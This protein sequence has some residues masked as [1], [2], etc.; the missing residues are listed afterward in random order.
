[1]LFLHAMLQNGK[2]CFCGN[3]NYAKYGPATCSV[4]CS[5]NANQIC[6]DF[7]ANV[8]FPGWVLKYTIRKTF[9]NNKGFVITMTKMCF[10]SSFVMYILVAQGSL[11]WG[12]V[13]FP[14]IVDL[15]PYNNGLIGSVDLQHHWFVLYKC[16]H[17]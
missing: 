11:N 5:G 2:S 10:L 17:W 3:G 9:Q 13:Y 4:P 8:V 14:F 16:R 1:M 15:I 6:G 7:F 12:V